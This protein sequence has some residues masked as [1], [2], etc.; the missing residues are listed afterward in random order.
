MITD[1]KQKPL[2][3]VKVSVK[4]TDISTISNQEGEYSIEVPEGY[5]I[6]EFIK[7]GYHIQILEINKDVVNLNLVQI[8]NIDVFELSLEQIM[9]MKVVTAAKK[10]EIIA[11]IPA[12]VMVLTKKDIDLY[13]F[14]SLEEIFSNI[15]GLYFANNAS[16]LG[17]T[18]GVRGYM[19]ANP[20]NIV[21]LLNGVPQQNDLHNSFSFHQCPVPVEAIDR[22]EVVRGPMSVIYGSNAFFGA[23]NIVT[24][25]QLKTEDIITTAAFSKG[26]YGKTRALVAS[27]GRTE[28]MEYAFNFSWQRDQGIDEPFYKMV[29]NLDEKYTAWG[30]K[31]TMQS[32]GGWFST[33]QKYIHFSGKFKNLYL[34]TGFAASKFGQTFSSLFYLPA[35]CKLY[36][37]KSALGYKHDFSEKFSLNA[38]ITWSRFDL[39]MEDNYFSTDTTGFGNENDIYSFGQ[40][41]SEKAE[42][43]L[44]LF[45]KP[46]S[47]LNISFTGYHAGIL[48]VGDKTDA[49]YNGAINLLNRSGGVV[50]GDIVN[51]TAFYSQ[52]DYNFLNRFKIIAGGRFE[53]MGPFDLV[54]YRAMYYPGYEKFEG[55]FTNNH[56]H[57]VPRLALLANLSKNHVIKL[58]YG[59]AHKLPAVWELRNNLTVGKSLIP[60][61]I[62]TW[63]IN[64]LGNFTYFFAANMSIFR[65]CISDVLLRSIIFDGNAY[66][67]YFTNGAKIQTHGLALTLVAIPWKNI[68]TEFSLVWQ[69]SHYQSM[70]MED[71]VV[72]FSPD[73]LAYFKA[74]WQINRHFSV[75]LTGNYVDKMYA[76]WDNTPVDPFDPLSPPKGRYGMPVDAWFLFGAN[77]RYKWEFAE[78]TSAGK[79]IYFNL[80]LNNI[81]DTEIHY[82]ST[83]VSTWADKGVMGYGRTAVISAA[84]TF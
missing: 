10:E 83:S 80:K 11:E 66:S 56:F 12:S 30:F 28:K 44:N 52:L 24:N 29:S 35:D 59:E 37:S 84:Y 50:E 77:L 1:E 78:E 17:P 4:T 38:K 19:T 76:Q 8:E 22:I 53:R 72:E 60:E 49:P 63:E 71:I 46:I 61:K 9:N 14:K 65:N 7:A 58:M 55:R 64:Y 69:R 16:F 42:A 20:T 39:L 25:E 75:A 34:E 67:S 32:S 41:W 5:T 13:G 43:E 62:D 31:D 36:F 2:G 40:Y 15:S 6:L 74:W 3:G 26:N 57:F 21:V 81:F 68:K 82:P 47:G 51:I 54:L 73:L 79:G 45:Y 18:I 70:N 23:I 33:D 27:K 48:D